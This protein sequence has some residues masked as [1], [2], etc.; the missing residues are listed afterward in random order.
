MKNIYIW[1]GVAAVVALGAYYLFTQQSALAPAADSA[2]QT[3]TASADTAAADAGGSFNG[4]I[5]DLAARGGDWKCSVDAQASTGAGQAVSSGTVYVSGNKVHGDFTSKVQGY[6]T[7][8]SHLISDGAYVYSWTS[9]MAQGVK[10]KATAQSE[11]GTQTSG[12]G[13][14]ANQN[15]AYHCEPSAADATLFTPPAGVKFISY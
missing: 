7:V 13:G 9:I 3:E 4:S 6:G 11:G 2:S 8:D 12:Q 14:D 5:F 15:Y 1:V 10:V